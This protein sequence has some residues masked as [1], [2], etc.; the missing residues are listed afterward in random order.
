MIF[1][2]WQAPRALGAKNLILKEVFVPMSTKTKGAKGAEAAT[3][4]YETVVAASKENVEKAVKAGSEAVEKALSLSKE[5]IEAAVKGY[6][7]MTALNKQAVE[8]FMSA[9]TVASK[10][11]EQI[12][13][14]VLAFTK[15]QIEDSISAAKALMGAKTLQELVDLQSD[16]ARGAF[17]AYMAQSTKMGE[18][19]A[20]LAQE[21]FE[22]INAQLQA[23]VEKFVKPLAA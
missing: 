16:Y 2:G 13:A 14:E 12:N 5:R 15:T 3:K 18:L 6:D 4:T 9:G 19:T 1:P 17:D 10:G 23:T 8:A 22:P 21:A 11:V 20:K 7:E